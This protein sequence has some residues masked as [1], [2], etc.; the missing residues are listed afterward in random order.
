[1]SII[2]SN[3]LY[4]ALFFLSGEWGKKNKKNNQELKRKKVYRNMGPA[5]LFFPTHLSNPNIAYILL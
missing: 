4:V 1:M 5:N 3:T 2:T